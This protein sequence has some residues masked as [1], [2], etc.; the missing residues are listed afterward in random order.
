[1][2]QVA[3]IDVEFIPKLDKAN[4]ALKKMESRMS[5]NM[6]ATGKK[7][8]VNFGNAFAGAV[9]AIIGTI[10]FSKFIDGIQ[11]LV[12]TTLQVEEQMADVAK[13]TGLAGDELKDLEKD[14]DRLGKSTRTPNEQLRAIAE[15]AGRLGIKGKNDILQF[16]EA[17]NT[18]SVALGDEFTGGAEEVTREVGILSNILKDI[19]AK[20]Q[21]EALLFIGNALN[22]LA[23][24]TAGTSP[25]YNRIY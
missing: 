10:S 9:T 8:G 11:D 13:T 23:A 25:V 17:V 18:L 16:T 1:M 15:G 7:A 24:N 6:G 5:S 2:S 22:V 19:P 20:D 4:S 3:Q 14:L 12:N 21:G